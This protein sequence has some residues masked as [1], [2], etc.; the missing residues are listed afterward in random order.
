MVC[1]EWGRV[2]SAN[3]TVS[4]SGYISTAPRGVVGGKCKVTFYFTFD[5]SQLLIRDLPFSVDLW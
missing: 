1:G 3:D 5:F 4:L 2:W